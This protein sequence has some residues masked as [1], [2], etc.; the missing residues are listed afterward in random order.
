ME[1]KV[2]SRRFNAAATQAH[3]ERSVLLVDD[4][5]IVVQHTLEQLGRM[6]YRVVGVAACAEDAL[7]IAEEASPDIVLLDIQLHGSLDG[8]YVARVLSESLS[9]PI[10]FLTSAS[11]PE[12][13]SRALGTAPAGY[14]TKPINPATLRTTIELALRNA[15]AERT[16][17]A[18]QEAEE[19]AL[20][21][22]SGELAALAE[23]L[24]EQSLTDPLTGLYNRRHFE[25]ALARELN[26]ADRTGHP[27]SLLL[28]D[29]D[30]FKHVNDTHGHAAG[31]AALCAVASSMRARLRGYDVACRIGG[32]EF[33]I[34]V[35]GTELSAATVL[36]EQLRATIEGLKLVDGAR[37]VQHLSLSA[38][39]AACPIHGSDRDSLLH[40]AD[41]ALYAAKRTGRDRVM[42]L[43]P[44][45]A[46]RRRSQTH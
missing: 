7:R 36:A 27:L 3:V 37:A 35:P 42:T 43:P 20:R 24:R 2:K 5:P 31:D 46:S 29:V 23:L 44:R 9:I 34:I 21:K 14:L 4:D 25:I 33:A 26:R 30:N 41:Q 28:F 19:S 45:S 39:V 16:R 6:R 8:I 1:G 32:D 12:T 22:R 17:R 38:G 40:A 15:D 13:L 10:V 18:L 11:D